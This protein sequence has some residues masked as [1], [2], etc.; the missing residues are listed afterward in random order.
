ML[1][2]RKAELKGQPHFNT[3]RSGQKPRSDPLPPLVESDEEHDDCMDTSCRQTERP[4]A[5]MG[6]DVEDR[7]QTLSPWSQE[8]ESDADSD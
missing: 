1:R 7:R 8:S 4:S 3:K 5:S 2:A 6:D